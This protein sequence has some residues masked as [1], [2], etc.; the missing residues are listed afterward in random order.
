MEYQRKTTEN[1]ITTKHF[2]IKHFIW[3]FNNKEKKT[4][5]KNN[6]SQ[7]RFGHDRRKD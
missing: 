6:G 2:Y 1:L 4:K 7:E 3:T 5:T